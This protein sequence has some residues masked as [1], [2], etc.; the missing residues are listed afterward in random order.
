MKTISNGSKWIRYYIKS[1]KKMFFSKLNI[2]S[3]QKREGWEWPRDMYAL[4]WANLLQSSPGLTS[5]QYF[6]YSIIILYII[7]Q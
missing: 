3:V 7:V 6:T 1:G 2:W 5:T 4:S